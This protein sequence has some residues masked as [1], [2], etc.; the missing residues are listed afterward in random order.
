LQ[1]FFLYILGV[2]VYELSKKKSFF[3]PTL[4]NFFCD[5]WTLQY[6]LRGQEM[7]T[8]IAAKKQAWFE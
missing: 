5:T 4:S 2:D 1:R 3:F 8:Y 7:T 6:Q